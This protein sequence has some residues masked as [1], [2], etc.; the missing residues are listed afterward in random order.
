MWGER[1]ATSGA[2]GC[3]VNISDP[4]AQLC[5]SSKSDSETLADVRSRADEV[6]LPYKWWLMDSWWYQ[7]GTL[8]R[9]LMGGVAIARS[10]AAA[11]QDKRDRAARWRHGR[12]D[13]CAAASSPSTSEVCVCS[14]L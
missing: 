9:A 1:Y 4:P 2:F 10:M 14:L 3:A 7:K 8:F 11:Q 12:L 6:S 5:T 13:V